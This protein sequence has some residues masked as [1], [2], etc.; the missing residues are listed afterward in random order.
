MNFWRLT[1]ETAK[2]SGF[3]L[4]G[5]TDTPSVQCMG[6]GATATQPFLTFG[7]GAISIPSEQ[8]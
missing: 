8:D 2:V 1:A 7:A 4:Y 6:F 3:S 5:H